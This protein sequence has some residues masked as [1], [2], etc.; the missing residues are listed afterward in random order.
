M[1]EARPE[2]RIIWQN[3]AQDARTLGTALI[4]TGAARCPDIAGRG[5]FEAEGWFSVGARYTEHP[6][7]WVYSSKRLS[8]RPIFEENQARL[9]FLFRA[10]SELQTGFYP[11]Q[12]D[13][14]PFQPWHITVACADEA[15]LEYLDSLVTSDEPESEETSGTSE[16]D[17]VAALRH[18][19]RVSIARVSK[20]LARAAFDARPIDDAAM[21]PLL[22]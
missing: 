6:F 12:V 16:G 22:Y 7:R 2:K 1:T 11:E 5:V 13:F 14:E 9:W 19:Q 15:F 20:E 8:K 21:R 10:L 17:V 18:F 3:R 4:V